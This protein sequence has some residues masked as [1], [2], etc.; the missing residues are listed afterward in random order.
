MI[1]I[2]DY[3]IGNLGSVKN[4]LDKMGLEAIISYDKKTIQNAD[5]LIL[6]G[7]GAAGEG[8]KNLKER[9]LDQLIISE[10]KKEKPIIGICLGMQ[11]FF[12]SSEENN[13]ACLGLIPGKVKKFGTGFKVP[14]IGWNQV[15]IKNKELGIKN[16]LFFKIP[17]ESYFYF[18]NSY[19]CAPESSSDSVGTTEYGD[20]FCSVVKKKNLTG[21]QFHP[22]KSGKV[23]FQLLKNSLL[24]YPERKN[25]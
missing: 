10:A 21:L 8:M 15:R 12:N 3:N 13:T 19:Y 16:N 23:G 18:V 5:V 24:Q 4:A 6:P 22:E 20:E 11:L 2:I 7:V 1:V 25:I 14:Q 9:K 17:D